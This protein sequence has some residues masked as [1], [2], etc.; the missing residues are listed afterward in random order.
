MGDTRRSGREG[1]AW[2]FGGSLSTGKLA[3][4]SKE[5]PATS[6]VTAR[7]VCVPSFVGVEF[8]EDTIAGSGGT[9]PAGR[10]LDEANIVPPL[11]RKLPM[12]FTIFKLYGGP[13][14]EEESPLAGFHW[15][16][17]P[18][19]TACRPEL[20]C[21]PGGGGGCCLGMWGMPG[22]RDKVELGDW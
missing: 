21:S 10:V 18:G 11:S 14:L 2:A 5:G 22:G 3:S 6:P 20:R 8:P 15:T 19:G 1:S 4:R 7:D 12:L 9:G 13:G 16:A 17:Q